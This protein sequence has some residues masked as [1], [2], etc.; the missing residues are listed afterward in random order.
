MILTE[1]KQGDVVTIDD[2]RPAVKACLNRRFNVWKTVKHEGVDRTVWCGACENAW[3][4]HVIQRK[5]PSSEIT[6]RGGQVVSIRMAKV[7]S[8]TGKKFWQMKVEEV[9]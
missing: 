6:Q 5:H 3:G 7:V 4:A 9:V 8:K 1:N 2:K